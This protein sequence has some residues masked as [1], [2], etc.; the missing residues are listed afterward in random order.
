MPR[1]YGHTNISP[2]SGP[3]SNGLLSM[4]SSF[5]MGNANGGGLGRAGR[6]HHRS[7]HSFGSPAMAAQAGMV[8]TGS[9]VPEE[10]IRKAVA[11]AAAV[12]AAVANSGVVD[13][14]TTPNPA[15]L[16]S[17]LTSAMEP[18]HSTETRAFNEMV[19]A[20]VGA[21]FAVGRGAR[22][23]GLAAAAGAPMATDTSSSASSSSSSMLGIP[24]K[25]PSPGPP[26][27]YPS[28]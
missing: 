24:G 5:S 16:L 10:V 6:P 8:A 26:Q 2:A 25:L 13:D 21:G 17:M 23:A 18:G 11:A 15:D 28:G 7:R 1:R 20:S 4:S 19:A 9:P 14:A 22:R 3:I 27:A 12:A